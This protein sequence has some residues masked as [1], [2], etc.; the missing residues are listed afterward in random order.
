MHYFLLTLILLE[1]L[2]LPSANYSYKMPDFQFS[3]MISGVITRHLIHCIHEMYP[4][5]FARLNLKKSNFLLIYYNY[6]MPYFQSHLL[7]LEVVIRLPARYTPQMLNLQY[8]P[9][10]LA[11]QTKSTPYNLQM[12]IFQFL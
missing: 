5:Q 8:F 6:K 10:V 1:V 12:H 9:F 11:F 3:L 4:L 7:F 2:I